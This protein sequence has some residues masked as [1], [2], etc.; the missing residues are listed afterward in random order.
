MTYD[1][2][3]KRQVQ[4]GSRE[5]YDAVDREFWEIS[6]VFAHP[7]YPRRPPFHT[8][9]DYE[10]LLGKAVLE[11]GCGMGSHAAVLARST[12]TEAI[13]REIHRILLPQPPCCR[14]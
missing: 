6:R 2:E 13:A 10:G 9:I 14:S 7:D 4:E 11:I 3:G 5:W 8:L 1:W 12:N